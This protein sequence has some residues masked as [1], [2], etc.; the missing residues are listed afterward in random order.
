MFLRELRI[1]TFRYTSGS[2]GFSQR[3][4]EW[5]TFKKFIDWRFESNVLHL[6]MT[7]V[8]TLIGKR[9]LKIFWH[10]D[11]I[12][13][14]RTWLSDDQLLRERNT[15]SVSAKTVIQACKVLNAIS[16]WKPHAKEIQHLPVKV[17]SSIINFTLNTHSQF[18][19]S[20]AKLII[21]YIPKR[22]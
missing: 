3:F 11:D 17:S 13:S 22:T 14:D 18:K 21:L 9:G 12:G 8:L 15:V 7:E 16:V 6:I 4:D 2:V 10:S 20:A 19:R 1:C 5:K